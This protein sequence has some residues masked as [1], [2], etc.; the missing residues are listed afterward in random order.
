[1]V[2]TPSIPFVKMDGTGNDFIIV[3]F[4]D[5]EQPLPADAIRQWASRDHPVTGG[6][7]QFIV[8]ESPQGDADV[9]MRIFNA[10]GSEAGACGNATRCVAHRVMQETGA[11]QVVVETIGGLLR[12]QQHGEQIAV[13]MGEPHVQWQDIPLSQ[14]MDT[15]A[16]PININGL[17][18]PVA[19]SM[20]NP[21]AV[22][23][24]EDVKGTDLETVGPEVQ[25]NPLFPEGVNVGVAQVI[26]P[27]ELS[28]R[29]YERGSGETQACGTGACAA[30]VAGVRKGVCDRAAT[31]HLRGGDLQISWDV[32]TRHV[33]MTGPVNFQFEGELS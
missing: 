22:F 7:D 9:F 15:L 23:F 20:G 28:L 26:A 6:C 17:N 3:D 29:V 12:C 1:M 16:L 11:S 10:D 13:D 33:T 31:V 4:R 30:L 21:H 27:D 2:T 18:Q 14:E 19:V 32:T 24:V 5:G 25:Q 8:M